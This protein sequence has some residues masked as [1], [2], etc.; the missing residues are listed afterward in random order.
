M[1]TSSLHLTLKVVVRL[2]TVYWL[3]TCTS[4]SQN[5]FVSSGIG[6]IEFPTC[7]QENTIEL[8]L[9][10]NSITIVDRDD[11]SKLKKVKVID[12]SYNKI[13]S[14]HEDAFEHVG[15]LEMLNLSHNCI[16]NLSSNIFHSNKKLTKV[17]LNNNKLQVSRN[18]RWKEHILQ[19]TSVTHLDVSF[20]NIAAISSKTFSGLPNLEMLNID[21][22]PL[23][24]FDVEF[25]QPLNNL[26]I[27]HMQFFN[28]STFEKFCN[29]LMNHGKLT[30]SP[31]CPS[32]STTRLTDREEADLKI[33]TVGTIMCACAFLITVI[34]YL[35][36]T[37]CKTRTSNAVDTKEHDSE[38]TIQQR[39]LPK[40]AEPNEGYEIPTSPRYGWFSSICHNR[41]VKRKTGYTSVPLENTGDV[42]RR[43][44]SDKD[45]VLTGTNPGSLHSLS[46]RTVYLDGIIYPKPSQVNS[47]PESNVDKYSTV[48]A[49]TETYSVPKI[50]PLPKQHQ[51]PH[52]RTIFN[53]E[54]LSESPPGPNQ[55][56]GS[57]SPA[58]RSEYQNISS[59]SVP[60][61]P[62]WVFDEPQ[63]NNT[64]ASVNGS[65]IVFVSSTFIEIGQ[66]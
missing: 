17:H 37:R 51:S 55:M 31:P 45:G 38:N 66:H 4:C 9:S 24:E 52:M 2:L 49:E 63:V 61:E 16:F 65:E 5:N 11:L 12:L 30:L 59:S 6:L 34:V 22:N 64:E 27:M 21:G 42:N 50:P 53:A 32:A 13:K 26:K 10:N 47:H 46:C 44:V 57:G 60:P 29:H 40:P 35:L 20:C 14:V 3:L 19:S 23:T 56:I 8:D 58:R 54:V 43:A 62:T 18:F 7:L 39:R 36:T 25:I 48:L 28:S 41:R 1:P 33:L 15:D